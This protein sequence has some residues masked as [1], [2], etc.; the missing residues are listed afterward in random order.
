MTRAIAL[1]LY[2][3]PKITGTR[4]RNAHVRQAPTMLRMVHHLVRFSR[5]WRSDTLT[6]CCCNKNSLIE[7]TYNRRHDLPVRHVDL[8]CWYIPRWGGTEVSP[9]LRRIGV[10][11]AGGQPAVKRLETLFGQTLIEARVRR[12]R[13]G[14]L[15]SPRA[16][17]AAPQRRVARPLRQCARWASCCASASPTTLGRDAADGA[18]AA[19]SE[20]GVILD[21]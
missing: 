12:D 19:A 17:H 13:T 16:P 21:R 1:R 15:S 9:A 3:S 18:R 7:P 11:A 2:R 10:H 8:I 14:R 20:P 5:Q 4:R 6:A